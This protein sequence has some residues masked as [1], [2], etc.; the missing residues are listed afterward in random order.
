MLWLA[1]TV[2]C[3]NLAGVAGVAGMLWL[4]SR[5]LIGWPSSTWLDEDGGALG[6]TI[7]LV[8]EDEDNTGAVVKIFAEGEDIETDFAE[9]EDDETDFA[10]DEDLGLVG[11][12]AGAGVTFFLAVAT[13]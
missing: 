4:F 11:G 2:R 3:L 12:T 5:E 7:E 13:L 1:C 10:E 9:D 6:A 8:P